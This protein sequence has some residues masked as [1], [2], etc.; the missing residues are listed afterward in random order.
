MYLQVL[1]QQSTNLE[2][3]D[4]ELSPKTTFYSVY[5]DSY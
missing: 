4:F 1:F 3:G 2:S 5:C